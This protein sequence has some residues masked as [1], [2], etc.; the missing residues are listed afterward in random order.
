MAGASGGVGS[1]GGTWKEVGGVET[2]CSAAEFLSG[3]AVWVR[4]PQVVNRRLVGA[5]LVEGDWEKVE[6]MAE[7]EF[8]EA[9]E[10]RNGVFVRELIPR[11]RGVPTKRE[12]VTVT[13]CE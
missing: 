8:D 12:S 1:E 5:V 10:T 4:R 7:R 2:D 3:V 9:V 6:E 11:R 13:S